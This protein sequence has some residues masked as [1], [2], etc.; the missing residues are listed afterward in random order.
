MKRINLALLLCLLACGRP[1]QELDPVSSNG[2]KNTEPEKAT[3]PEIAPSVSVGLGLIGRPKIESSQCSSQDHLSISVTKKTI[4]IDGSDADWPTTNFIFNLNGELGPEKPRA[5]KII[6]EANGDLIIW[7]GGNFSGETNLKGVFN[8]WQLKQDQWQ[9]LSPLHLTLHQGNGQ[10]SQPNGIISAH[11]EDGIEIRVPALLIDAI[12][13]QRAWS[14]ELLVIDGQSKQVLHGTGAMLFSSSM[15]GP[16]LKLVED[17]ILDDARNMFGNVKLA[18]T[19]EIEVEN[20]RFLLNIARSAFNDVLRTF[21]VRSG[22]PLFPIIVLEDSEEKEL[23]LKLRYPFPSGLTI[24]IARSSFEVAANRLDISK[25][26]YRQIA[27]FV[28]QRLI[29]QQLAVPSSLNDL[30]LVEA[31]GISFLSQRLGSDAVLIRRAK[32]HHELSLNAEKIASSVDICSAD[33]DSSTALEQET[34]K[35][36]A[37]AF[38]SM[39]GLIAP[40]EPIY[41]QWLLLNS[42][43]SSAADKCRKLSGQIAK[44]HPETRSSMNEL[45]K[46]WTTTEEYTPQFHPKHFTDD[47]GDLLPNF[48]EFHLASNPHSVDS[49]GDGWSD[50]AEFTHNTLLNSAGNHPSQIVPDG[51]FGD[52]QALLSSRIENDVGNSNSACTPSMDIQYAGGLISKDEL[53]VVGTLNRS[54]AELP[55]HEWALYIQVKS[56]STELLYDIRT[57]P[58]HSRVSI[59]QM[60]DKLRLGTRTYL[61]PDPRVFELGLHLRD[62]LPADFPRDNMELRYRF[63]IFEKASESLMCDETAWL[64]PITKLN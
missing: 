7:F 64:A 2:E 58:D 13:L 21:R 61:R 6:R 22:F 44:V 48:L 30:A 10:S 51:L 55:A 16:M 35:L 11:T 17:C 46:G 39:L 43:S 33:F 37:Q 59:T 23:D 28:I 3:N 53:V 38:G 29:E 42:D 36:K 5:L 1:G 18:A 40:W 12:T 52:W 19:S 8:A 4:S 25:E 63:Q 57:S 20:A 45:P 34:L 50:L 9:F 56:G 32:L 31:L 26:I 14:L 47:D 41:Q 54:F 27:V 60:Q 24:N 15:Q 62:F 49:D